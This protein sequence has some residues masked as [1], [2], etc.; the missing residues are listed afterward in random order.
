MREA[1]IVG[2]E[3]NGER[4]SPIDPLLSCCQGTIVSCFLP[5]SSPF[6]SQ[7]FLLFV[8]SVQL[9]VLIPPFFSPPPVFRLVAFSGPRSASIGGACSMQ[10]ACYLVGA[11]WGRCH[12][13]SRLSSFCLSGGAPPFVG[14]SRRDSLPSHIAWSISM[15]KGTT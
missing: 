2:R 11:I 15:E 9:V 12:A 5:L 6:F 10:V 8:S 7:E 1:E 3:G 13:S 4:P 14:S